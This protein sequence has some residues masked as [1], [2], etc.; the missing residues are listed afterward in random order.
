MQKRRGIND[1]RLLCS[2]PGRLT[3]VLAI[4]GE[5]NGLPLDSGPL[6]IWSRYSLSGS[7]D[8]SVPQEIGQTIQVG[9]FR[10]KELPY[11]FYL[12]GNPYI[13]VELKG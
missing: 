9:I 11:R 12:K 6:Q 5:Y 10:A 3:Q 8:S 7:A 13:S 4:T 2:G 1:L